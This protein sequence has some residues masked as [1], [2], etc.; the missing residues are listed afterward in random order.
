MRTAYL[1]S[2]FLFQAV[3]LLAAPDVA[4]AQR[5]VAA[6][7]I[8]GLRDDRPS[9]YALLHADVV[10]EPGVTL[11]DVSVL[12]RG[13]T[14]TAIGHDIEIPEGSKEIDCKGRRIYAGLIDAWS[15]VESDNPETKSGYWNSNVTPQRNA[16]ESA[17]AVSDASK[18]RSQGIVTRLV[19][20][21]G[22]IVKGTSSVVLLDGGDAGRTLLRKKVFH[23]LQ[24]SVPRSGPR[25]NYPNSP[26]GATAL[27]R[28]SLYDA[29]WYRDAWETYLASAELPRPETNV[30]LQELSQAMSEDR[31]VVDAPNERM[32]VRADAMA[33]EFSL[34]IIFRG[35]GREY[36]ALA[37][38]IRANRPIL[39]PVDFPDAPNVKS[40]QSRESVTLQDLMHWDLAPENPGRLA[41]A[42]LPIC[43]TTDG[44]SNVGDFLKQVRVAVDRGLEK[45]AA[46]AAITTNPAELLQIDDHVGRV[47]VGKLANLVVTNGDLFDSKTKVIESWVAGKRFEID[48]KQD[49][50]VTDHLAGQWT[51]KVRGDGAADLQL[52][53]ESEGDKLQGSVTAASKAVSPAQAKGDDDEKDDE[54][55][56]GKED[57]ESEENDDESEENDDD[58]EEGDDDKQAEEKSPSAKLK[59]VARERDRVVA[60]LN[61][62][63]VDPAYEDGISLLSVMMVDPTERETTPDLFAT[64]T[65]P[66]GAK[67][68]VDLRRI[69]PE[70]EDDSDEGDSEEDDSEEDDSEEDTADDDSRDGDDEAE[71]GESKTAKIERAETSDNEPKEAVTDNSE[72]PLLVPLGAYGLQQPIE[73]QPTVLLRGATIWTCD[74]AGVLDTADLLI[75]DGLIVAV[76]DNLEAP[77]GCQV[78]D[79]QGKHITPGLIDCH[80]HMGTDGGVNESGQAVT[81]EVRIGDFIDNSD[82]LIYRHLAGGVTTSNILHGSANPIGGQNQV[83]K[84]RW[85]D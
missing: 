20:P 3:L 10:V 40:P 82:I 61:L 14:I 26:M 80:S 36:R 62:H 48:P 58:K 19:A 77:P 73:E 9:D 2:I 66:S 24:L 11:D 35:S 8:V 18:L 76:G 31:F 78:F 5:D 45:D 41:A 75:Q 43:L 33:R 59:D 44:L 85:G 27:L 23:H 39:V 68:D 84:L 63:E 60:T 46:L 74:E 55:E 65:L 28:Q 17:V 1:H 34:N 49:H 47:Q 25:E 42:G 15:E 22:G 83:I 32:A 4:H 64:I 50:S 38:I 37:S 70:D 13:T 16:A 53:I 12:I 81:A 30:A 21:K 57:D 51:M 79:V 6:A 72:T 71:E 56:E 7:P 67:R 69:E 52:V 54:N 29:V